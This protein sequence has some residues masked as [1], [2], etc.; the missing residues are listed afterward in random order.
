MSKISRQ[1]F[2]DNQPLRIID[3]LDPNPSLMHLDP[4]LNHPSNRPRQQNVLKT[5]HP[6]SQRRRVVAL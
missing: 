1:R 4:P 6:S 5:Q 3:A 2:V